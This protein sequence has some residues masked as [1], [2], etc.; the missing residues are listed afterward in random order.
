MKDGE[1]Q[2]VNVNTDVAIDRGGKF[3][4]FDARNIES[5]EYVIE[6]LLVFELWI[7]TMFWRKWWATVMCLPH[8]LLILMTT[9]DIIKIRREVVQGY[10]Y[11]NDISRI[12]PDGCG[13]GE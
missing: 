4:V 11:P 2:K 5:T 6:L 10:R 7:M 13:G 3:L 9:K 12:T 1:N 8:L